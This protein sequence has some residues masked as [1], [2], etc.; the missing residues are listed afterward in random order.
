MVV[1]MRRV[2][3]ACM[4]K[5]IPVGMAPNIEVSLIVNPDDA[6]YLAPASLRKL[7][8]VGRLKFLKTLA[9]PVFARK[10]RPAAV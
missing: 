2:F 4:K 9:R 10:M 1:V 8:Y 3:E 5:G 6:R 7:L